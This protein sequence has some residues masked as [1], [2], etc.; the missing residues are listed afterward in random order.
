MN[1]LNKRPKPAPE[2]FYFEL[3]DTYAG[4][5]NYSWVKRFKV[6]ARSELAALRKLNSHFHYRW[7]RVYATDDL[8]RWDCVNACICLFRVGYEMPEYSKELYK[9][10]E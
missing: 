1:P 4:E 5:A 7:R 8:T 6:V 2:P 10:L 3:T 9:E